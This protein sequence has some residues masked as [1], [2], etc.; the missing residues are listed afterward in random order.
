MSSTSSV[1]SSSTSSSISVSSAAA[2]H[3]VIFDSKTSTSTLAFVSS[4]SSSSTVSQECKHISSSSPLSTTSCSSSSSSSLPSSSSSSSSSSDFVF[5][6]KNFK[7]TSSF[8]TPMLTDL[9]QITMTY[10]YFQA[11]R[12]ED[13]SVFDLFFRKNPFGGEFTVF[14]GLEECLRFVNSFKF[15]K[16]DVQ[17][18]EDRFPTWDKKFFEWL[19]TLTCAEVKLYAIPEGT[20]VFPRIPLI[21]VEGP[22]AVCQL[23]ETT[24]LVLV[25][26]ASL[27]CTN[28][29]RHRLAVGP[30]KTLLE[31]GLR[32]AQ[33]PDGAMSGSRYA[34][35]GLFDGT[36]NVK[37]ACMFDMK[38]VGTH[39]HSFVSTFMDV[40]EIKKPMLKD[41]QGKKEHN[42]VEMCLA[43]KDKL[44]HASTQHRGE[45]AAFISYA[46]AFPDSFLALVDTYDTL[47]SGLWNFI[48]VAMALLDLG[49]KPRGIR[50]DSG[51][52]SYL[53]KECR[54]SFV[55]VTKKF[56]Y[57]LA[58]VTIVASNDISEEVLWSLREQGHEIDCFGIGTH[59]ITC[60]NQPALGCV[61]KLV[62]I[63]GQPRIKLSQDT[64]KVT[65][66]GRKECYRLYNAKDE[67][68]LDYMT[69]IDHP[70][71]ANQRVLCRHPFDSTKR[72]YVTPIKVV[73]LHELF[74]NGKL[75]QKLPSL[76]E[77][78]DRVNSQVSHM[79]EDY[80]RRLNPTPYKISLSDELYNFMHQIWQDEAPVMELS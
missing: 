24:L 62:E 30:N 8:V 67:P 23:L 27:V 43:W 13:H 57:D 37:A 38:M 7:P 48:T 31:F 5:D 6:S 25:N 64:G 52:L 69:T 42:F 55:E 1:L 72:A 33:G 9:Y 2:N 35:M 3:T 79:R 61:Y 45:L 39:A 28:A 40:K 26:Y 73:S 19:A 34:Y 49:Y 63:N 80:I 77:I 76:R 51:D 14:A 41:A 53:S 54:K 75:T 18:L 50:L 10:A 71:K 4:S 70:V 36:S 74:W 16:E 68:I 17:N 22:L 29:V 32:R 58:A 65:I 66:P 47:Q 44:G 60:K 78:R 12:H 59:L 21:R 11:G 46:L 20:L 15:T 56:K